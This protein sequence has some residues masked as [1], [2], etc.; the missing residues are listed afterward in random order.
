MNEKYHHQRQRVMQAA[1]EERRHYKLYRSRRGWLVAGLATLAF[2]VGLV[3]QPLGVKAAEADAIGTGQPA[4]TALVPDVA[5]PGEAPD[6]GA[7]SPSEAPKALEA[8]EASESPV[9]ADAAAE[10]SP[11]ADVTTETAAV[12]VVV[13]APAADPVPPRASAVTVEAKDVTNEGIK[14]SP[15]YE[16][17]VNV[18]GPTLDGYINSNVIQTPAIITK[19]GSIAYLMGT[20]EERTDEMLANLTERIANENSLVTDTMQYTITATNTRQIDGRTSLT[21]QSIVTVTLPGQSFSYTVGST[22]IALQL[23]AYALGDDNKMYTAANTSQDYYTLTTLARN[24]GFWRQYSIDSNFGPFTT[25]QTLEQSLATSDYSHQ[26]AGTTIDPA[27]ITGYVISLYDDMTFN[28]DG[29]DVF[30]T[31]PYVNFVMNVLPFIHIALAPTVTGNDATTHLMTGTGTAVGNTITVITA[32]GSQTATTTVGADGSWSVDTAAFTTDELV[33]IEHN[34]LGDTPGLIIPT[35]TLTAHETIVFLNA[36]T[37]EKVAADEH[38]ELAL[39]RDATVTVADPA[40]LQTALAAYATDNDATKLLGLFTVVPGEWVDANTPANK[41]F[42]AIAQSD[43]PTIAGFVKQGRDVPAQAFE[44]NPATNHTVTATAYYYPESLTVDPGKLTDDPTTNTVSPKNDGDEVSKIDPGPEVP[45]YPAG[46]A[47][48]DLTTTITRTIHYVDQTGQTVAPDRVVTLG[49][50]RTA[51]L[52]LTDLTNLTVTGYGAWTLTTVAGQPAPAGQT[53][54]AAVV[55]PPVPDYFTMKLE[56][57]EEVVTPEMLNATPVLPLSGTV[58]YYPVRVVVPPTDPKEAETLIYP[59]PEGPKY[60]TGVTY[61]DLNESVT[62]TIRYVD[63]ETNQA[64]AEPLVTTL[65][66]G[67]VATIDFTNYH[68][69]GKPAVTYAN[70]L[71]ETTATFAEQPAKTFEN[72]FTRDPTQA[73]QTVTATT[74]PIDFTFRYEVATVVVPPEGP[75]IEGI[76]AED[77]NEAVTQTIHYVDV[78]TNEALAPDRITTLTFK[79]SALVDYEHLDAAGKP[80]ITYRDWAA[81]TT[82]TFDAQAPLA[83]DNLFTRDLALDAKV[84]T[85]TDTDS[86][87]TFRYAIATVVVPPEGPYIEGIKADD[88]NEAVTQTIHYVDVVTNEA[89]APDRITTLTFKRSALVDYEHLDAAGKPT[90]TYRDWAADTT[91]TFDAQAPLAFDN[92]FTRDLALDAKVVTA[93]DTDSDHTFRYAIATVVVPPEGPYIEGIKADDLNATVTQT[94]HYVDVATNKALAPDRITTL[95]FKRSALVD[96]EHLDAAGKPTITYRDW[97]PDTTDTFEAQAPLVFDNLFTRDLALDAKV[98]T[99]TDTDSDYTF[100]YAVATVVVPPD[101]P[102]T[103]EVVHADL[104]R[105][106]TETVHYVDAKT[107]AALAPDTVLSLDFTRIATVDYE[108]LTAGNPTVTYTAWQAK[109]TDTFDV[110]GPLVFDNLF[111]RDPALDAQTVTALSTPIDYTF[112]YSIAVVVVP[113]EGPYIEGLTKADLNETVTRTIQFVDRATGQLLRASQVDQL[114]FTRTARVDYEHLTAAGQPTITFSDWRPATTTTFAAQATPAIAGYTAGQNE[115]AAAEVEATDADLTLTVPYDRQ[116]E[117]PKPAETPAP[118][119]GPALGGQRALPQTGESPTRAMG[120]AGAL[121]L[122]IV[123]F[124]SLIGLAKRKQTH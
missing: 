91:D 122:A 50:T 34:D 66:F 111:T 108:H 67:R 115:V 20:N 33:V 90:I 79:R 28:Y 69:D 13:N 78:V 94:I 38:K 22:P 61:T 123:G 118:A 47:V 60:P 37:G 92:L 16:A 65:A 86:D 8:P 101:G 42:P 52:D 23:H 49:Y 114:T 2:G 9:L 32:D 6:S 35:Q 45:L 21:S 53:G 80:T 43:L 56:Y 117:T 55:N 113:P 19:D 7:I 74:G 85:A 77:L 39:S 87:H 110:Q 11:A 40:A 96:Y 24:D 25:N 70:W 62:Q 97:V 54:F 30:Q 75:Y 36:L 83:F 4:E 18:T 17:L 112:R 51:T 104:N 102:F 3:T 84:V 89:L 95:T 10:L 12:P 93:T 31:R 99:A 82:D 103:D 58:V 105:T 57:P 68:R 14:G 116:P 26:V 106:I 64:L 59:D 76:K 41:D 46:V 48:K 124:F 100:H 72:K 29:P 15:E 98:V 120:L 119:Q 5:A 73:A 121:T 1:V 44:V 107:G 27:H 63:V 109:T 81:D 88:L 71:P